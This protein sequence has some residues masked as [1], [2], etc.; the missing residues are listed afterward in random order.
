MS[1]P[2]K[3]ANKGGHPTNDQRFKK[4][5]SQVS[6]VKDS[7]SQIANAV[8]GLVNTFEADRDART[9]QDALAATALEDAAGSRG[10]VTPGRAPQPIAADLPTTADGYVRFRSVGRGSKHQHRVKA[11]QKI[12]VNGEV[13]YR[14]PKF[15]EF[16]NWELTTDDLETIESLLKSQ[17]FK[18]GHI[19]VLQGDI[20]TPYRG[21]AIQTGARTSGGGV[22]TTEDAEGEISAPLTERMTVG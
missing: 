7:V 12:L 20:P 4:L 6:E 2:E 18:D 22:T 19:I 16:D 5:E 10:I 21:P 17:D 11:E 14:E 3:P 15:V 9:A 8:A 13:V 1:T